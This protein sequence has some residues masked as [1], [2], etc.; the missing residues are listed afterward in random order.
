MT[1]EEEKKDGRNRSRKKS[2]KVPLFQYVSGF[3]DS[4]IVGTCVLLLPFCA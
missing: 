3:F 4:A 1:G 2:A